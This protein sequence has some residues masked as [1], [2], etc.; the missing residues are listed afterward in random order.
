MFPQILFDALI[1][2]GLFLMRVLVPLAILVALGRLLEKRL[3]PPSKNESER[4]TQGARIIPFKPRQS[5]AN[6]PGS[7]SKD[8]SGRRSG[9]K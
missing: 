1:I 4:R 2:V 8:E 6:R 7:L 9:V 5:A 3:S